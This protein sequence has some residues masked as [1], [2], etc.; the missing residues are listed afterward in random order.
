M[1]TSSS[2]PPF[3]ILLISLKDLPGTNRK[4]WKKL[5]DISE[6]MAHQ[7]SRQ[8]L[9]FCEKEQT[10]ILVLPKYSAEYTRMIMASSGKWSPLRLSRR[11]IEKLGYKAW[12]SGILL[13]EVEASDIGRYCAVC[14]CEIKRNGEEFRCKNNHKGNRYLN[15]ARNL[16]KKFL[17]NMQKNDD[18]IF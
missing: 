3:N 5:R 9:K 15:T 7:V 18:I 12:Q 13:V 17:N 10:A 14:G 11:I 1:F 6:D 16:G 2:I 8:I 4:H